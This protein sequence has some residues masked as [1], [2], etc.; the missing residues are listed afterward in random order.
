MNRNS[1]KR[2]ESILKLRRK[3]TLSPLIYAFLA[4]KEWWS[5]PRRGASSLR[6]YVQLFFDIKAELFERCFF[7]HIFSLFFFP[8]FCRIL[9]RSTRAMRRKV[10]CVCCKR[11]PDIRQGLRNLHRIGAAW[12]S[13]WCEFSAPS[14]R[15]RY[16]MLVSWSELVLPPSK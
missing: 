12:P 2:I 16:R 1:Q 11:K 9:S 13:H 14:R 8:Y 4:Q 15:S 10:R 3:P 5:S 7:L 6:R